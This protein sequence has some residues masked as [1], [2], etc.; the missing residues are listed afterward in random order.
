M[1]AVSQAAEEKAR[2]AAE[3][4]WV[5][6]LFPR[7]SSNVAPCPCF[8]RQTCQ[9]LCELFVQ[10]AEKRRADIEKARADTEAAAKVTPCGHFV[11]SCSGTLE[12]FTASP[13]LES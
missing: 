10:D 8:T 4:A 1:R 3:T 6:G 7:R 11:P 12:L 9:R 13:N 2:S 5:R